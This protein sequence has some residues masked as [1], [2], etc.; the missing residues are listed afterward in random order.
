[1]TEALAHSNNLYFEEMGRELG[2][3]R[4]RHYATQF[5]LGELAGYQILGEQLG[6]YPDQE[7]PARKAASP[8]VQLRPGR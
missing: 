6:T 1:M 4:V 5:G 8:H 7:I 2:F 3:E